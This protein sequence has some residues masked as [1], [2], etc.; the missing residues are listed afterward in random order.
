MAS[1]HND[2]DA[3]SGMTDG[4]GLGAV[5]GEGER[6][7]NGAGGAFGQALA[8]FWSVD[9]RRGGV[10]RACMPRGDHLLSRSAMATLTVF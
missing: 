5:R 10:D 8:L 7:A 2:G 1:V 4:Y 3:R 6:E 9:A